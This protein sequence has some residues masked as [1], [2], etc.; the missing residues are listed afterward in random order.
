MTWHRD[1]N[2]NRLIMHYF[3]I[4]TSGVLNSNA[5]KCGWQAFD[6]C[7]PYRCCSDCF[8]RGKTMWMRTN[9]IGELFAFV[10]AMCQ[11]A[12]TTGNILISVI[13]RSIVIWFACCITASIIYCHSRSI[14]HSRALNY[15]E[16][17]SHCFIITFIFILFVGSYIRRKRTSP[18]HHDL[19]F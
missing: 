1:C 6:I 8:K 18:T 15:D 14:L 7:L 9:L 12:A 19:T 17:L 10:N 4:T 13:V 5:C 3:D 11:S 2:L 16:C